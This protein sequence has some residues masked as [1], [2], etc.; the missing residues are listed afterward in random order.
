MKKTIIASAVAAAV[1]APAAFADVK[2]GG[3]VNPEM[4]MGESTDELRVQ[5]DLVFS[6]SEDLG[7]GLKATFKYH[8]VNDTQ[9]STTAANAGTQVVSTTVAGANAVQTITHT[10]NSSA[11]VNGDTTVGDSVADLTVTLS[12]DF[13]SISVGRQEG[14]A[15][16]IGD[17]FYNIDAAHELDLELG[18][19]AYIRK[20]GA[21][22]YVSPSF[23]GLKVGFNS[24]E[25]SG[26]SN[27][28]TE[29]MAQYSN[30]GLGVTVISSDDD[31][32]A[33][34]YQIV[35]VSYKMGDLELRASAREVGTEETTMV[36]A[37]YSMGANTF[38]IGTTNNDTATNDETIVSASHSLSKNTSVY[39]V[40][41]DAETAAGA[42]NDTTIIGLR[43]K[44]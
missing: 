39:V 25:L 3:M 34:D 11:E 4:V 24:V 21:I 15:E 1:A 32:A 19:S 20:N 8:L 7:N 17:A 41:S 6:G 33:N 18:D 37:K 16:G 42:D 30:N 44:F 28:Q 26:D 13:G 12:G 2:I 31:T 23:N 22:K 29:L 27:A 9:D 43:Q 14:F 36:G 10:V 38:A 35:N 40:F 5:T